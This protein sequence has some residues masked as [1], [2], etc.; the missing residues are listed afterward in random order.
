MPKKYSL[1]EKK[2]WLDLYEG[3]RSETWIAEEVAHCDV[4]TVKKGIDEARQER[5]ASVAE[6]EL[7]KNAIRNHQDTLLNA[8]KQRL[9]NLKLPPVDLVPNSREENT[10][11]Y[12]ESGTIWELLREHLKRDPIWG[13]LEK[14]DKAYSSYIESRIAFKEKTK[15]LLKEKTGFDVLDNPKDPP[16]IHSHTAVH[17]LYQIGLRQVMEMPD[18]TDPQNEIKADEKSGTVR[19]RNSVFSECP[20]DEQKCAEGIRG[21]FKELP[22]SLEALN[23]LP[24][25]ADLKESMIK[26]RRALEELLLLEMI[27]GHCRVCRRLGLQ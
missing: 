3:G 7:L 20:G 22:K 8:M 21:A 6:V 17:Q 15:S 4:R 27:P 16:F 1:T 2:N 25:Y 14:W 12:E 5:R 13:H 10:G 9:S 18:N 19:F 24:T 23:L 11:A 26:A